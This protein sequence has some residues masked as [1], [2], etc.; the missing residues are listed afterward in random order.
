MRQYYSVRV[1]C[2]T[3][4]PDKNRLVVNVAYEQFEYPKKKLAEA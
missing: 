1:F 2:K 4:I 3:N